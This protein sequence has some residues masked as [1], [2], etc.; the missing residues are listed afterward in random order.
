MPSEQNH[1]TLSTNCLQ[2]TV[3]IHPRLNV[4]HTQ[5]LVFVYYS[6]IVYR[7]QS[8]YTLLIEYRSEY[9]VS[10]QLVDLIILK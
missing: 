8:L 7:R 5:F 10:F 1:C 4:F 3:F 2:H 9:L 6:Q